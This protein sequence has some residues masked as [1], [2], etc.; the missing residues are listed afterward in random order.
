M[1]ETE[2]LRNYLKKV[3]RG[4]QPVIYRDAINALGLKPPNTIHQLAMLLETLMEKV[5]VAGVP[6]LAALVISK[7]R[8][9]LPAPGFFSKSR[10]LGLYKGPDSGSKAA[11][12]HRQELKRA[13][14]YWGTGQD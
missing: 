13:V 10:K 11:E 8:G 14:A 9:G 6:L 12:F 4:G 7:E 2:Q 1:D 5:A 3:A